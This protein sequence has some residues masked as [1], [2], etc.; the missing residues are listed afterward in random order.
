[1]RSDFWESVSLKVSDESP[2]VSRAPLGVPTGVLW[3]VPIGV[4]N[5][6][7]K[8]DIYR[9]FYNLTLPY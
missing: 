5:G 9:W 1:M 8:V 4:P 2:P 7:K 3:G 6:N